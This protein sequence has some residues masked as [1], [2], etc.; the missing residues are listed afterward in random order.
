[1]FGKTL[2]LVDTLKDI[3]VDYANFDLIN[4][5]NSKII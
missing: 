4:I 3:K 1:M 5:G 2:V